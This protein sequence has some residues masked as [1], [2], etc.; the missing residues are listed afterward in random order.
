MPEDLEF[1]VP[2]GM[3]PEDVANVFTA[4]LLGPLAF[5]NSR[6]GD[7]QPYGPYRKHQKSDADW[8]LDQT[9]DYWLHVRGD[10]ARIN[11]RYPSQEPVAAAMIVL[12]KLR[13]VRRRV[14]AA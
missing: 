12:F 4:Y 11:C 8:Q 1:D 9:N 7:G 6:F 10:K 3:K 2:Q 5:E 14:R 13:Y